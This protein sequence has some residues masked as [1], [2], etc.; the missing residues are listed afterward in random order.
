M[1]GAAGAGDDGLQAPAG[2]RLGVGE[3]VVR[4]AVRRDHARLVGDV[5]L[6]EDLDGVLQGVPV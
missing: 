5:E 6:L 1:R 2:G 3:H 4:H